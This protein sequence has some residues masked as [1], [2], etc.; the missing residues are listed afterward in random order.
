MHRH[1]MRIDCFA[2]RFRGELAVSPINDD[3]P[4]T[5]REKLRRTTFVVDDVRFLMR[6]DR[7]VW[8]RQRRETQ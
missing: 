6:V 1:G 4:G 2:E 3:Q 7:T 5:I 8:R